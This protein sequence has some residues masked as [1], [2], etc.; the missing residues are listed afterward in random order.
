MYLTEKKHERL[1]GMF[2]SA[3]ACVGALALLF[4]AGMPLAAEDDDFSGGFSTESESSGEESGEA[5]SGDEGF[6]SFGGSAAGL[7]WSGFIATTAR[8]TADYDDPATGAVNTYPELGLDLTYSD[9]NSEAVAELRFSRNWTH[10]K[11][12]AEVLAE[13]NSGPEPAMNFKWYLQRMINQAHVRLFYD[14]FDVQA[15]FLKEV[16]GTGDK[17]HVVD[18][19]NATDYYDFVNPDYMERKIAEFMFKGN[20]RLGQNGRLELVYVPTFTPDAIPQTGTWVPEQVEAINSFSGNVDYPN[21]D[22]MSLDDGQ[23]A[24]RLKGSFGGVDLGA[25]YYYGRSHQPVVDEIGY[26]LGNPS[27]LYID[28]P[29]THL[30][31][32]E[33]ATAI[34]GFNLRAEAAF[35]MTDDW[36]E[37]QNLESREDNPAAHYVAGFDR[38]LGISELN[39][40]IQGTGAYYWNVAP[41]AESLSNTISVALTDSWNKA[42]VEPEL[43]FAYTAEG[44]DFFAD[45]DLMLRP[46]VEFSLV[47]DVSL[48]AEYAAYYGP[49]DGRFGQFEENDYLQLT[50][51]YAF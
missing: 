31:G 48:T 41:D 1:S 49:S 40:N 3:A 43:A 27:D 24:A 10:E 14:N 13:A 44:T 11:S 28:Y 26:T 21:D 33:S 47:D 29:R 2:R 15:G 20:V 18:P 45:P 5:S 32:L 42:K 34:K 9:D 23:Y 30:F 12:F 16:W 4:A 37:D 17:V 19:L 22:F 46:K 35:T 36:D 7:E 38:D 51:D 39:L 8:Y 50:F 25:I 6:S